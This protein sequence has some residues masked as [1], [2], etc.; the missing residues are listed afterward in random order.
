MDIRGVY[1][2][3]VCSDILGILKDN[4]EL[5]DGVGNFLIGCQTYEGGFCC[6]PYG[7]AH[8]GYTFC[9]LASLIILSKAGDLSYK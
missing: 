5:I 3:L 7:E 4:K 9:A 8:G 1:C 6:S 2:S